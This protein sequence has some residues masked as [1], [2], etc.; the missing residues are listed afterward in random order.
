M[1]EGKLTMF[2]KTFNTVGSTDSNFIIKTKGDLKV[3]WGGKFIDIIKNGK[4]ASEGVSI[5]KTID[6]EDQIKSDGIY[7]TSDGEIWVCIDG[8]KINISKESSTTYV[9][10]LIEQKDVTPDQKY[11][12][13]TNIGFY[14]ETIEQVKEANIKTGIIFVS[15]ESKLYV[16]KN[17]II[18]EYLIGNSEENSNKNSIFEEITVGELRIHR[19]GNY[20][21]IESPILQFWIG[22][23][24]FI[25]LTNNI[26]SRVSLEMTD[27]TYIQSENATKDTGFRLYNKEGKSIL[28]IDTINLR[29]DLNRLSYV[30][31]TYQQLIE[32]IEEEQLIFGKE[33]KI[34]DFQNSWE[35]SD[36]MLYEDNYEDDVLI[37]SKNVRPIIVKANSKNTLEPNSYFLDNQEWTIQYNHTFNGPIQIISLEND[38]IIDSTEKGRV[39]YLKDQYGN[40]A[41]YDFKHLKFQIDD[42][43]YYTFSNQ[44]GTDESLNGT[45]INNTITIENIAIANKTINLSGTNKLVFTNPVSGN[46]FKNYEGITIIN[47]GF[48]NNTVFSK[49]ERN[50]IESSITNCEF[51]DDVIDTIFSQPVTDCKFKASITNTDIF[52]KA[53]FKNCQVNNNLSG[54]IE[55]PD[56]TLLNNLKSL[57]PKQVVVVIRNSLQHLSITSDTLLSIPSGV[58]LMWAGTQDIPYG[59]AMCNGQNGTPNLIGRFIKAVG[60]VEDIGEVASDLNDKN[61]LT[62]KQ[63]NLPKH[64][65]P[66]KSHSHEI[67]LGN[68]TATTEKSGSLQVQL[69]ENDYNFGITTNS[70][71]V[72]T[73]VTGEGVTTETAIVDGLDTVETKGGLASGG[74]HSHNVMIDAGETASLKEST[75]LENTLIDSEWPNKA[76]K[77]EP[78]SYALIFIMKL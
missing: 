40:S 68:I 30:E 31:V 77:I 78:R 29:G 50:T 44:E 33:Y 38:T 59:W 14:Y 66:H 35:A 64:S 60:T 67:T 8:S 63:E 24:L 42:K 25:D 53:E 57:E 73:S 62:I 69:Q 47:V 3:Q 6:S 55:V 72:V 58:I 54:I 20:M 39:T 21:N 52:T 48:D 4:L 13:L 5:L 12:A 15:E 74:D 46:T 10:F 45:C 41:N 75:S 1:N 70:K 26:K 16:V 37:T 22:G 9:S 2:G 61:E 71:T 7:L 11:T 28:D 56:E 34:K 76:I 51:Q 17:G 18:T 23:K 32:L 27:G 49:W 36:I 65:H 43:W 19:E